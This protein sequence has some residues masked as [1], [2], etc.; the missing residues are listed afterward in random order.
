M[1]K[2]SDGLKEPGSL[3]AEYLGAGD[4][5]LGGRRGR[6]LGPGTGRGCLRGLLNPLPLLLL[7]A[8]LGEAAEALLHPRRQLVWAQLSRLGGGRKA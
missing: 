2:W 4:E 3:G 5:G 1:I 6:E 7:A 8:A